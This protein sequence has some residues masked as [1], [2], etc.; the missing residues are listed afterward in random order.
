MEVREDDS[1]SNEQNI[2]INIGQTHAIPVSY[3]VLKLFFMNLISSVEHFFSF[4]YLE[5][6]IIPKLT[7]IKPVCTL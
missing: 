6:T 7:Y 2:P 4:C 3:Y 5:N 1:D